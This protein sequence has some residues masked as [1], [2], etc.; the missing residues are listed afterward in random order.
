M[1][2]VTSA[3]DIN[4]HVKANREGMVPGSMLRLGDGEGRT[5]LGT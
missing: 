2:P 5:A 1:P 4:Q 3:F